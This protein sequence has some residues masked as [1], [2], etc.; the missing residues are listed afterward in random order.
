M[1]FQ[2]TN[3]LPH[4]LSPQAYWTEEAYRSE[5]E[6]LFSDTWHFVGTQAELSRPGDFLTCQVA[7]HPIQ[8]RNFDGEIVALSNVCAHRHALISSEACGNSQRMHCQYHGWEY[9]SD[10]CTR[11]IPQ[12]KNFVPFEDQ[13]FRIPV[14]RA[15]SIGQL[16]FVNLASDAEP[17]SEWLGDFA[18]HLATAF[19]DQWKLTLNWSP[20]YAANW[21][22]PVENSLES[23]HVPNVH[24]ETFKED[25]G[26]DRSEH[27]LLA[28]RT[29]METKLPFAPHSRI[30]AIIQN[31]ETRIVRWLGHQPTEAYSQHHVFPNLL[32]SF[33]D[34]ISLIQA[35]TP[36]GPDSC[37]AIVRQFSRQAE[38]RG[39]LKGM[40]GRGWG[41]FKAE[42]T[43]KILKEDR[44]M[45][46]SIQQ[47]LRSS[48]QQGVLGI[49]EERI[50]AFQE[51]L[52]RRIPAL[53]SSDPS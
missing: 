26:A 25:P 10:G 4:L 44:Q 19:G 18:G 52:V 28:K 12:P 1:A 23:Y 22:V 38:S 7:G 51:D 27:T 6:Q 35:V 45:F 40:L 20:E 33:T 32:F 5:Q 37:R 31:L 49:C 34:T 13:G 15:E 50:H 11:K 39:A 21:K 17:L 43:R 8:V 41:R 3:R 9:G 36:S 47:G 16:V 30:D 53:N 14:H 2:S 46:R 29:S 24:P 48:S 42:V